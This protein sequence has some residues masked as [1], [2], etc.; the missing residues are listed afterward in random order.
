MTE[1][2]KIIPAEEKHLEA[3]ADIAVAAW[4]PIREIFRRDLGDDAWREWKLDLTKRL[5]STI[6]FLYANFAQGARRLVVDGVEPVERQGESIQFELLEY[7]ERQIVKKESAWVA[8]DLFRQNFREFEAQIG[9]RPYPETEIG[10][11][12]SYTAPETSLDALIEKPLEEGDFFAQANTVIYLGK[13]R[14]GRKFRRAL[15]VMKH[16]GSA[17]SDEILFYEIDD[18]GL[19][20]VD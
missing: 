15:Y 14:D 7:V 10:T 3:A 9:A 2:V 19:K 18:A 6:A 20:I 12:L 4:T 16:R 13:I 17:C 1:E 11:L 8:R 5:Q